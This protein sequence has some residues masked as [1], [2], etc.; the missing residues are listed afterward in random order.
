MMAPYDMTLSTPL[1]IL[2]NKADVVDAQT[3]IRVYGALMWSLGKVI[4]TP[5]ASRVYLGS[6]WEKPLQLQDNR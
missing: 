1:R 4:Q 6:F 5:E 2:L 3:L